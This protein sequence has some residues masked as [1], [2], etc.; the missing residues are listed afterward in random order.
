MDDWY[1]NSI[2]TAYKNM[3]AIYEDGVLWYQSLAT[4]PIYDYTKSKTGTGISATIGLPYYGEMFSSQF[5]GNSNSTVDIWLMTK[6][7]SLFDTY[8]LKTGKIVSAPPM[9]SKGVRPSMYL[10]SSV[11]IGDVDG[12]GDVGNGTKEKPYEITM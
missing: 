9:V 4:G 11:K 6:A 7:S 8:I 3:I 10:K 1:N 12:D 2:S 5:G